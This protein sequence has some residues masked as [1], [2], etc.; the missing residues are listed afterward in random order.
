M[1]DTLNS[2]A[3]TRPERTGE[4]AAMTGS[5]SE[6]PP[7]ELTDTTNGEQKPTPASQNASE[8]LTGKKLAVVFSAMLLSLLRA[9]A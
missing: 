1:S 8:I 5:T 3:G 4:K 9:S 2:E 7:S 6:S